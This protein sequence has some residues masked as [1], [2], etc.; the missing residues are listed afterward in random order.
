[1]NIGTKTGRIRTESPNYDQ[2]D[3]PKRNDKVQGYTP[4]SPATRPRVGAVTASG[5][6]NIR[7]ACG[8]G[9]FRQTRD[10]DSVN[11]VFID[12][13]NHFHTTGHR[14]DLLGVIR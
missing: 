5:Q 10:P 14:V 8:C 9:W 1:M 6:S 4:P 12:A 3:K 13:V 7:A 2:R 11:S